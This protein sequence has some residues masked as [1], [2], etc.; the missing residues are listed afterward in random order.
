M[1]AF[2][3]PVAP[4]AAV[5]GRDGWSC[6]GNPRALKHPLVYASLDQLPSKPGVW[7]FLAAHV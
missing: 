4:S 7:A 2:P 5:T 3:A 6:A 1:P